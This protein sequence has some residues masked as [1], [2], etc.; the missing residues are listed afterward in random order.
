MIRIATPGDREHATEWWK[1]AVFYQVYPRSFCDTTGNGIG[2]L[3][4][5]ISGLDYL[6]DLGIDALWISPFYESPMADFGYD[7]SDHC[8]VDPLFGTNEDARRLIEAIHARGMRIVVDYVPNHTSIAH[9]WF[10]EASVD[11]QNP[12]RDYYLW[13]DARDNRAPPNNWVSVF[14]G[15]A[16]TWHEPSGQYYL[17][18]FLKEQ[19]DLNWE[20]PA[21]VEEMHQVLHFW[22]DLG[23]DGFRIDAPVSLARDPLWRDNPPSGRDSPWEYDAWLHIH[24]IHQEALHEIFYGMRAVLDAYPPPGSRVAIA[25]V[26]T[27]PWPE[28]ARYFGEGGDEIQIPFNFALLWAEWS[29]AGTKKVV[30]GFE[31]ALPAGAWPN[32]TLGNHDTPRLATRLGADQVRIAA[33]LLLTLR[34]TPTLYYGDELGLPDLEV[35]PERQQDPYGR[36]VPGKGRDG[37]RGPMLFTDDEGFGF[38]EGGVPPWLDF[39]PGAA[40]LTASAQAEPGSLLGLYRSLLALR[41]SSP[42]LRQGGYLPCPSPHPQVFCFERHHRGERLLVALNYGGEALQIPTPGQDC[43]LLLS[44]HRTVLPPGPLSLRPHEGVVLQISD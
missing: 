15:P 34:G 20:N 9:R 29:P 31:A 44:T 18:R 14:G 1:D 4:G 42:T 26:E 3:P 17:H 32:Y 13:A 8:K 11:R 43:T 40:T 25:E 7:V 24:D 2:D 10:Q 12:F 5:V 6:E 16:W 39:P 41:K 33:M 35:P 22:L 23:V 21:V 28:W 30:D 19:P 37:C 38:S 27:L 36:R